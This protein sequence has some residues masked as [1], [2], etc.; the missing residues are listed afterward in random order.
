MA[1]ENPA[2]QH[3]AAVW[4]D[5]QTGGQTFLNEDEPSDELLVAIASSTVLSM[6]KMSDCDGPE[7]IEKV[8]KDY[9]NRKDAMSQE[10][11]DV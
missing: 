7:F 1:Q 8:V 2:V 4:D 10:H 9:N 3:R 5:L 6:S 11:I